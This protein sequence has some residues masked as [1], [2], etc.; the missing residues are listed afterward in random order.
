MASNSSTRVLV[1]LCACDDAEMIV[2]NSRGPTQIAG[3]QGF[4]LFFFLLQ[5]ISLPDVLSLRFT[6]N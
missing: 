1:S 6:T 2:R 4:G 3:P 5:I